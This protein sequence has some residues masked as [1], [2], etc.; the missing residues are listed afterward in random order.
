MVNL[1]LP[2]IF[3][4]TQAPATHN[5]RLSSEFSLKIALHCE[6]TEIEQMNVTVCYATGKLH[7][8]KNTDLI[9]EAD[10]E[11][12]RIVLEGDGTP[13]CS[14][15]ESI[16]G[17]KLREIDIYGLDYEFNN[18]DHYRYVR[19]SSSVDLCQLETNDHIIIQYFT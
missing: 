15:T 14:T 5:T 9:F 1:T 17:N 6:T 8:T 16:W 12:L 7:M 10:S 3:Q 11:E 4:D 13:F 19:F 2:Y 18:M